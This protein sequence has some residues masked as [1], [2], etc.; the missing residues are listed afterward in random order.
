MKEVPLLDNI[1]M[2]I[3]NENQLR[4]FLRYLRY[5]LFKVFFFIREIREIRGQ[6][7]SCQ[8]SI[9]RQSANSK[10]HSLWTF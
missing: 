5:L 9:P 7:Y 1:K 2:K 4:R 10:L 3:A 8:G 6:F